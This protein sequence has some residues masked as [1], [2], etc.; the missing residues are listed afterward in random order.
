MT[1]VLAVVVKN[2]SSVMVVWLSGCWHSELALI[3]TLSQRE[4]AGVMVEVLKQVKGRNHG[5]W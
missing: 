3:L 5:R 2:T 4:R 1:L